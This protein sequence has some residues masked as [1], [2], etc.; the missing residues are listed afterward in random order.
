VK[1]RQNVRKKLTALTPS[2]VFLNFFEKTPEKQCFW[3]DLCNYFGFDRFRVLAPAGC[4]T[5][6]GF[7]KTIT[8]LPVL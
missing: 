6:A 8:I 4:K 5:A 3:I 1:F 2:K 7:R